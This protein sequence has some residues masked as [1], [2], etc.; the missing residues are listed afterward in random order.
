MRRRFRFLAALLLLMPG[1]SYINTADYSGFISIGPEGMPQGWEFEFSPTAADS[2]LS[3]TPLYDVVVAVRYTNNCPSQSVILNIEEYS[4]IR[5]T[6]DSLTIEL[7]LFSSDGIP[8]GKSR[9]GINEVTDTIHR[10]YRIEEGYTLSMS[11][12]LPR[13]ATAGVQAVGLILVDQS[14][15]KQLNRFKL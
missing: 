5:E 4:L 1:C 15:P 14:R 2:T 10:G 11:S 7:P 3:L 13:A 8:L 6:P 9:Y 12:P